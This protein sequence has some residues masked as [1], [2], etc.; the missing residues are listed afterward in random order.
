MREKERGKLMVNYLGV[1]LQFLA[2]KVLIIGI[3]IVIEE[4][5]EPR[6]AREGDDDGG[7]CSRGLLRNL[8]VSTTRILLQIEV[9][10]FVLHLQRLAKKLHVSTSSATAT[11]TA[12]STSSSRVP[13][14]LRQSNPI[15]D[16]DNW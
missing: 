9:K 13:F 12:A 1:E 16:I 7:P 4:I 11:S 10:Q 6:N 14:H 5:E 2:E 3:D 8:K 15:T